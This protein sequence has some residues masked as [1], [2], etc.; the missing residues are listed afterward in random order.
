[1]KKE[2]NKSTPFLFKKLKT[3]KPEEILAAGG[4]EAFA[5]LTNYDPKA[6]YHFEGERLSE[7][8]Y[9]KAVALLS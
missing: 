7:D 1:M 6:L 3:Y 9:L 4:P 5:K 8:D 2:E